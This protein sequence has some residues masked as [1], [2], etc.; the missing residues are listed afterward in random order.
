MRGFSSKRFFKRFGTI[1]I[2]LFFVVLMAVLVLVGNH[3]ISEYR[4]IATQANEEALRLSGALEHI[5]EL[6]QGYVLAVAVRSGEEI[7]EEHLQIV[8]VPVKIGLNLVS[9]A[10]NI[11]GRYFRISLEPGTVLTRDDILEE[12]KD[13]TYRY[14][15]LVLDDLPIGIVVGDFID[16]RI[17][18]PFG[19][20]FIA[21]A[22]KKI[23]EIN[24]GI[25]KV[26]LNE[27]EINIF[28]SL[29]LDRAV[30]PGTRI[31][32]VEYLDGGAQATAQVYYPI[33]RNIAEL[34]AINPNLLELVQQEMIVRRQT[35]DQLVG[36]G[37]EE[38]T[39]EELSRISGEIERIRSQV[40]TSLVRSHAELLMRLEREAAQA[41]QQ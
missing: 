34:A 33:N 15:D 27:H 30:F 37:I 41:A 39:E 9:I 1:I 17:V 38:K 10:D 11:V 22:H 7:K 31:Y 29:M 3:S 20:D 26:I 25:P 5:G 28:Q 2:I 21:I 4:A 23:Q 40:H 36:G 12:R 13:A 18:F 16:V 35:V 6:Q 19:E 24:S 32:A 8:D 14:F